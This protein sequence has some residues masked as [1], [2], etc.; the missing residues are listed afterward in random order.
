MLD[1]CSRICY[2]VIKDKERG[3]IKWQNRKH[4]KKKW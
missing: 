2:N 1:K 3:K 4:G